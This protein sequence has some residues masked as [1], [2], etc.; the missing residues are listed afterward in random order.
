MKIIKI[1]GAIFKP[2]VNY[3]DIIKNIINLKDEP[4]FLVISAAGKSTSLLRE[5]AYLAVSKDSYHEKLKMIKEIFIEIGRGMIPEVELSFFNA[6]FD[7]IEKV[8]KSISL[9]KELSKRT[10][11]RVLSFGEILTSLIFIEL[12]KILA[13]NFEYVSALDLI[14]TDNNYGNSKPNLD[15]IKKNISSIYN[16]DTPINKIFLTEGFIGSSEEGFISTM[17]WESSNLT[18]LIIANMLNAKNIELWTDVAGIRKID[19]KLNEKAKLISKIDYTTA[20]KYA[21]AGLNLIH[22]EMVE[23]AE[24]SNINIIYKSPHNSAG[25]ETIISSQKTSILSPVIVVRKLYKSNDID[26]N[27]NEL[28]DLIDISC[29]EIP[30]FQF[31]NSNINTLIYKVTFFHYNEKTD[32]ILKRYKTNSNIIIYFNDIIT[33]YLSEQDFITFINDDCSKI[34]E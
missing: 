2:G 30:F 13:L 4:T 25:L 14:I 11:D 9:T 17:G 10:L 29:Q 27:N 33:A 18:A 31:S 5:A 16:F 20:K 28:V 22:K 21:D 1:G 32:E 3:Q 6:H 15:L 23:L 24:Q 26:F 34:L 8:L 12:F 19:P 7:E